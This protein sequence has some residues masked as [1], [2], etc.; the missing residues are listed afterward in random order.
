MY[1]MC[2]RPSTMFVNSPHQETFKRFDENGDLA[3]DKEEFSNMLRHTHVLNQCLPREARLRSVLG[4]R[5]TT[6]R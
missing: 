1:V 2:P 4:L 5:P 6:R 3:L